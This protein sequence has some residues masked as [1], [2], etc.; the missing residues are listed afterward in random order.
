MK[1]KSMATDGNKVDPQQVRRIILEQSKRANVGHI[2]SA[3]SVADIIAVLFGNILNIPKPDDPERDRFVLSKGHA[4]LALYAVLYLKKWIGEEQLNEYCGDTTFVGTH[5]EHKLQGIDF[6]TG[7][8]GMGLSMGAGA[9]LAARLQKS[10]RRAFVLISDA[11]CNEGSTWEAIMFAAHHRLANLIAI[12]DLN[13]QQALGYT[14]QVLSLEPMAE[15]WRA[16]KWDVREIDGHD[17]KA[18]GRTIEQLDTT[19]GSPHVLIARTTFGKGV[20]YMKNQIKWHYLPMTDAEYQ[21][22]MIEIN[23]GV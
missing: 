21:Q 12:V 9:A 8:L 18:I 2:G 14:R 3:L 11:E 7:S 6:S 20:S 1:L 5:P 17:I 4:A 23:L 15:K 19:G 13:G 22:A 10:E 16:F